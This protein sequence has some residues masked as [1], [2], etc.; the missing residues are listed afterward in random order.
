MRKRIINQNTH[1]V[2]PDK[3]NW[4]NLEKL[5]QVEITSEDSEYPIETALTF[6]D[7][8]GWRAAKAGRQTIRIIF[9]VAAYRKA[10]R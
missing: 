3:Q 9:D 7:S 6:G 10:R 4:F 1:S 5:A 8:A 2:Q